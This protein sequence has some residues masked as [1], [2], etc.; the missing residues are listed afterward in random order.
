[1]IRSAAW[2]GLGFAGAELLAAQMPPLASVSAAALLICFAWLFHKRRIRSLLFGAAAGG[3]FFVLF[4]ACIV[5]PVQ[6]LAGRTVTAC[7]EVQTDAV[8]TYGI[9]TMQGTLRLYE[10][11]GEKRSILVRCENIP[12]AAPG[13][14]F[15]AEFRLVPLEQDRFYTGHLAVGVYLQAECAEEAKALGI[16]HGWRFALYRLRCRWTERLMTQLPDEHLAGLEAAM[17]L[18]DRRFLPSNVR[19]TFRASGVSHLLAVSGLHLSLLCGLLSAGRFRK[20][21]FW[22]PSLLLRAAAAVFYMALT[23][24]SVSVCR[25]G[26]MFLLALLADAWL[27]PYD[28]LTSLGVAAVVLGL[29]NPYAPCEIGFQLSFC[30][31]LGVWVASR[32]DEL[33]RAGMTQKR[34]PPLL[35]S[36]LRGMAG[37][38]QGGLTAL[39]ASIATLPVLVAHGLAVSG[40]AVLTNLLVVWVLPVVLVL[41][42]LVLLLAGHAWLAVPLHFCVLLLSFLLRAMCKIAAWC[43]TLPLAQLVL[44]Q[45]YTLWVY[46]VL[47]VLAWSFYMLGKTRY[48]VPIGA[49]FTALAVALG[50]WAQQ[51]IITLALVGQV[52]NPCLIG[53]QGQQAVVLYRG[54]PANAAAVT[55]YL[56]LHG[57]QTPQ[58][59][60]DLREKP[61]TVPPEAETVLV[62]AEHEPGIQTSSITQELQVEYCHDRNGSLAVL[63]AGDYHIALTTGKVELSEPLTVDLYCAAKTVHPDID[64]YGLWYKGTPPRGAQNAS[65]VVWIEAQ[66]DSEVLLRAQ[67]GMTWKGVRRFAVQ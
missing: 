10:V 65:A 22:W 27:Q 28:L 5:W 11:N 59:L 55:E 58:L 15:A 30:A 47:A 7:A 21:R 63:Q 36:I 67:R 34:H 42:L 14:R 25:A 57:I 64:A 3:A 62:L 4:A 31:V 46:F 26:A 54:G 51:G 19:D 8:S 2:F 52:G 23:G 61:S 39:C 43:A 41:G 20:Y 40:V 44:P 60:L 17:L 35:Q 33:Y 18:G 12:A 56:A 53:R 50:V 16:S 37:L 9:G 38:R 49:G 13:T 66:G 45:A 32:L 29:Q 48:F 1:M 24:F 6:R